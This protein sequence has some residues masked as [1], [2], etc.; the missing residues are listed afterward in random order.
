MLRTARKYG[1]TP[2]GDGSIRKEWLIIGPPYGAV[3]YVESEYT[4]DP[5]RPPKRT[6]W[7]LGYH[8]REPRYSDQETRDCP[9]IEGQCYYD[10]SGLHAEEVK[11]I[12]DELGEEALW[13]FL[14]T[15][16]REVFDIDE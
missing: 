6:A 13:T 12:L 2:L 4:Y 14:E 16:F 7:D 15:Y 11:K 1:E 9:A 3:Q 10:G 8:S 5:E